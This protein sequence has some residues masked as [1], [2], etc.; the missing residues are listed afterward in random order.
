MSEASRTSS[1][2]AGHAEIAGDHAASTTRETDEARRPVR[3]TWL[4]PPT[5]SAEQRAELAR[6]GAEVRDG[7]W[8][9]VPTWTA[10]EG[11]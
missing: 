7:W 5:A 2:A 11:V 3:G 9:E 1:H 4:V 6:D 8:L 10:G